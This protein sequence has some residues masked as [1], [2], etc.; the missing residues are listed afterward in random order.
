VKVKIYAA[1][2]AGLT[3]LA[4]LAG[5]HGGSGAGS[6]TGAG[7]HATLGA[8]ASGADPYLTEAATLIQPCLAATHLATAKSCIEGKVPQPKRAA[9][10]VC[11]LDDVAGSVGKHGASAKFKAGAA[12]CAATA[13][14]P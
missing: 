11:L 6:T 2:A 5:C 1:T 13:L 4:L 14:R 10:R 3:A 9:L 7:T 8:L 12:T